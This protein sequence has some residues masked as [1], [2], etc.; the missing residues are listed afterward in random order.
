LLASA[1]ENLAFK[2]TVSL[3]QFLKLGGKKAIPEF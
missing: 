1:I 2:K 3:G